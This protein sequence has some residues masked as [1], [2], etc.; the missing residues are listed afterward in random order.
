M[1]LWKI[2]FLY[3]N[4][5]HIYIFF[6]IHFFTLGFTN[7]GIYLITLH[8]ICILWIFMY[9]LLSFGSCVI[10]IFDFPFIIQT[11]D[12]WL[13]PYFWFVFQASFL[14]V[15]RFP[16]RFPGKRTIWIW[17]PITG[18]GYSDSV[19][20][21]WTQWTLRGC[22][23]HKLTFSQKPTMKLAWRNSDE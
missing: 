2:R 3:Q 7:Y 20:P 16:C 21:S 10:S 14:P 11:T 22:V 6:L 12:R 19:Q 17:R 18:R 4:H 13:I 8:L 9:F 1:K 15:C 23:F 5:L